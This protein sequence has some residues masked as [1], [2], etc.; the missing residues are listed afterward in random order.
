MIDIITISVLLA[1]LFALIMLTVAWT[2]DRIERH[3][4]MIKELK[5]ATI[6]N[7]K[8]V[9][10]RSEDLYRKVGDLEA[11]LQYMLVATEDE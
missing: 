1:I 5:N 11:G 3:E 7:S 9:V 2:E 6:E 10:L 8:M 4:E